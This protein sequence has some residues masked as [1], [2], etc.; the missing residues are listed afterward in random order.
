MMKKLMM[1]VI[2]AMAAMSAWAEIRFGDTYSWRIEKFLDGWYD[3]EMLKASGVSIYT[4]PIADAGTETRLLVEIVGAFSKNDINPII[5]NLGFDGTLTASVWTDKEL[6]DKAMPS[7]STSRY[8]GRES[9]WIDDRTP[10][11]I[12]NCPGDNCEYNDVGYEYETDDFKYEWPI[13]LW[14]NGM[15]DD[16]RFWIVVDIKP[17]KQNCWSGLGEFKVRLSGDDSPSVSL[18]ATYS[19][20]DI[21]MNI[22]GGFDNIFRGIKILNKKSYFL[23]NIDFYEPWSA[24]YNTPIHNYWADGFVDDNHRVT[25]ELSE[26][27]TLYLSSHWY[28]LIDDDK[29]SGA[30]SAE[31]VEVDELADSEDTRSYFFENGTA[32]PFGAAYWKVKVN[33]KR[34][35]YIDVGED[36]D[37]EIT[38]MQFFPEHGKSVAVEA[39]WVSLAPEG[40]Y[41]LNESDNIEFYLQGYVTG[42]GVYKVGETVSL[43]AIPGPGEEFS[44]W[45]LMYGNFPDGID[46]TKATL[47]FKVTD[48]CAGSADERKQM[49]VKAVWRTMQKPIVSFDANYGP[50]VPGAEVELNLG[51]VGYTAKKLPSGLKLDKKTGVVKGKAKKPGE[52]QATFTKKG[53]ETLTAK[54]IVGPMPTITITMEGDIEKCKVTGASKPGN[55]YLVG[56]KVSLSAKGP[57]G[58]A[59]TGWFKDGA[60]WPNETEYLESKLK[61]VMTEENLSLVARFEKEKMSV[62]CDGFSSLTVGE[63]VSIPIAIETQSGVKSVTGSKLPTGLKVKKDKAT[64]EW[65]VT[66]KPKKVGAWNSVIKVTAKSGAVAQLPVAVTVED[67]GEVDLPSANHYFREPLKNGKGEKYVV[68][69]GISNVEEFL[70]SLEL[71]SPTAKLAVSGLPEGLKYDATNGKITGVATKPGTYTVTLTVTDGKEKYVSTIAIEV[72]ALPDWVVG[73]FEGYAYIECLDMYDDFHDRIVYTIS[74]DG[75]VLSKGQVESGSWYTLKN[76][77][78]LKEENG[79]FRVVSMEPEWDFRGER[80]VCITPEEID[81]IVVGLLS[82]VMEGEDYEEEYD[83]WNSF[84][85]DIYACQ[86]VWKIAQGTRLTPALVKNSTTSVSMSRMRDDD[87]DPYYGGYLTLKYGANG[88]VTTAYS[89][90]EGGKATATGS[91]QLVPYEV[92]GNITKAW[93]YTALKPKGRDAFGVLLFLSI[94]TSKGN[95]YGDDVTV[96]DYL[97]ELD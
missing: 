51:L 17:K 80:S 86:N 14:P 79:N 3:S 91:A 64:G 93:L 40:R 20:T 63:E 7:S 43:K 81:G 21:W 32:F 6:R 47:N 22:I 48:A 55:G 97:L 58:T 60:P 35:I 49:V 42:T 31:L 15:T 59:F 83:Y 61:Y 44:H 12:S 65:F 23:F 26:A 24:S 96:D 41:Q 74:S 92:D 94:D 54:F 75:R 45:E 36:D 9:G 10:G 8:W 72:E 52:Y 68:S 16:G 33:S 87:W 38:R 88:A 30:D 28:D 50:F 69:V 77:Q 57:K 53:A 1:F 66:G 85:G 95:V 19:P 76:N 67:K 4:G 25:L 13:G 71:N 34:K 37:F 56:K 11:D 84:H 73:T 29:I 89:E 70:P 78:L 46:T 62:A 82:G 2:A 27:G 5:E 90:T 18:Y 39:S